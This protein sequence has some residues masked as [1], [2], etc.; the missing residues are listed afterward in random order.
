MNRFIVLNQIIRKI[1]KLTSMVAI[2]VVAGTLVQAATTN[3][4]VRKSASMSR[5]EIR[6]SE[7][8]LS[9][10]GYWTGPVD[11]VLDGKTRQAL[12][13]FQK[14]SGIEATGRLN[15]EVLELIRNATAPQ[16]KDPGYRHVEIDLD[17]QVLFLV[18]DD[19]KVAKVLPVSTGGGHH[20]NEHGMSGI[21]YTPR[22]RFRVYAK[23]MGWKKSPLGMLYFPNY[24]TDGL[25]IHGNSEVPV[26]PNSH[27]GVRIPTFASAQVSKMMPVGTIVLIYDTQSFVSAKDWAVER[28]AT[29]VDSIQ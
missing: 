25:S 21:A 6:E 1:L 5:S 11:G 3:K 24:F 13:A 2:L 14:F 19:G 4:R 20:Y 9:D 16:A 10:L 27:G 29:Q 15:R 8:L 22:G 28:K 26:T 18:D 17:R 23:A 12:I 7:R